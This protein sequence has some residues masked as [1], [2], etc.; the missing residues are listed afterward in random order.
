MKKTALIIAL[1]LLSAFALRAQNS[2]AIVKPSTE[3]VKNI[4]SGNAYLVDVRTPEEFNG[5]HLQYAKNIKFQ[6]SRIQGT[7][8]KT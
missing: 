2:A 6:Q 1:L 8:C 7:A 4:K 5:G 3:V